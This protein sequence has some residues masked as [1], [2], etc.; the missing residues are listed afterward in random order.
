MLL[1]SILTFVGGCPMKKAMFLLSVLGLFSYLPAAEQSVNF[2]GN[3]VFDIQKSD[4]Q[5]RKINASVPLVIVQTENEIQLHITINGR[6]A[7]ESFRFDGEKIVMRFP[8]G[9]KVLIEAKLKGNT[10]E[11]TQENG[12]RFFKNKFTRKYSLS[13]D[14]KI[15]TV[16]I[17]GQKLVYKKADA[18]LALPPS[19]RIPAHGEGCQ[20]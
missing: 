19:R 17:A 10:F 1:S 20:A 11:I 18:A 7:Y 4:A 13:E 6:R 5:A 12:S 15:L 9:S 16:S 3:W 2:S 8:D 14:G